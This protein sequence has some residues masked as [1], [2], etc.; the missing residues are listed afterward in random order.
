MRRADR[1]ATPGHVAPGYPL[2]AMGAIGGG[3]DGSSMSRE[4]AL[5][6]AVNGR[7]QR[8]GTQP[9]SSKSSVPSTQRLELRGKGLDQGARNVEPL[10]QREE[11]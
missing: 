8:Q 4:G 7:V 10:D 11:A 5:T 1:T 9:P 6:G 2:L 3:L